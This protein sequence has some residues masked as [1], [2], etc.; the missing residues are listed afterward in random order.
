MMYQAS[1]NVRQAAVALTE[2]GPN[3]VAQIIKSGAPKPHATVSNTMVA[4]VDKFTPPPGRNMRHYLA[5]DVDKA[6]QSSTTVVDAIQRYFNVRP[7]REPL[8][9]PKDIA[10]T[11][12][13]PTLIMDQA[14]NLSNE[15]FPYKYSINGIVQNQNVPD[16]YANAGTLKVRIVG[17]GISS[18]QTPATV[19]EPSIKVGPLANKGEYYPTAFAAQMAMDYINDMF[20]PSQYMQTMTVGPDTM[21]SPNET[22]SSVAATLSPLRNSYGNL[23]MNSIAGLNPSAPM[24]SYNREPNIISNVLPALTI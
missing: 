8:A 24:A 6:G 11:D 22:L 9:D 19:G 14:K 23:A 12:A 17:P 1:N 16:F 15:A 4:A 13:Y 5:L 2:G 20:D 7:R 21:R 18:V 10:T 3:T